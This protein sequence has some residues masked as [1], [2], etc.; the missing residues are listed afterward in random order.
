MKSV[1]PSTFICKRENNAMQY[2]NYDSFLLMMFAMLFPCPCIENRYNS[3]NAMCK[4]HVTRRSQKAQIIV[5]PIVGT[6][7]CPSG[8]RELAPTGRYGKCDRREGE[9]DGDGGQAC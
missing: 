8:P 6:W 5:V 9:G 7:T 3:Y 4:F 2:L 1:G